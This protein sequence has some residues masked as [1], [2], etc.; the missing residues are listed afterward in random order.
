MSKQKP[1]V[2][3]LLNFKG[4][5]LMDHNDMRSLRLWPETVDNDV[6][7]VLNFYCADEDNREETIRLSAETLLTVADLVELV[8]Q[9]DS[10]NFNSCP[11]IEQTY[12]LEVWTNTPGQTAKLSIYPPIA[13][14][15][16]VATLAVMSPD[17]KTPC[18]FAMDE[19]CATAFVN[20]ARKMAGIVQ[21]FQTQENAD[22]V[23]FGCETSVRDTEND[24]FDP[25]FPLLCREFG[26]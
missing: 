3:Q 9:S 19:H 25:M 17:K 4:Q 22:V 5:L 24:K 16:L 7:C 15:Q 2:G 8:M 23:L 6:V 18:Q 26:H 1:N 13:E 21:R 11:R 20:C 12:C 14:D 10:W